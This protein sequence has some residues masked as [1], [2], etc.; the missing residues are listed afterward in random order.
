MLL[1]SFDRRVQGCEIINKSP[2]DL[3]IDTTQ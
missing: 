3:E 2:E 1:T